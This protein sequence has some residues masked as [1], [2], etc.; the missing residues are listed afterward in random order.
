MKRH[1]IVADL[2]TPVLIHIGL[3]SPFGSQ[4]ALNTVTTVSA[5][6]TLQSDQ[7]VTSNILQLLV[8]QA[9]RLVGRE[10]SRPLIPDIRQNSILKPGH[11]AFTSSAPPT[12]A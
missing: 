4:Q 12:T 5:A 6:H 1:M 10:S 3:F 2:D 11:I 7:F 8:A 9:L